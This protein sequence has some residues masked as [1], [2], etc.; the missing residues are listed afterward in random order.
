MAFLGLIIPA[1][2][3]FIINI[4]LYKYIKELLLKN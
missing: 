2:L 1:L 3:Q 4:N